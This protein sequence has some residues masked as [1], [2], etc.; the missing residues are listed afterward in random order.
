MLELIC[1]VPRAACCRLREISWV[2]APCRSTAAA[3]ADDISDNLSMVPLISVMAFT[4]V[5][6]N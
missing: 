5:V 3:I 6:F 4:G 1:W 2:A